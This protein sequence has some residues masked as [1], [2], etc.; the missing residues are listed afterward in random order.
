M[1]SRNQPIIIGQ[2][3]SAR[4]VGIALAI[5]I[6]VLIVGLGV[7]GIK[8]SHPATPARV[9][10]IIILAAL[11]GTA[12][13]WYL[14]RVTRVRLEFSEDGVAAIGVVSVTRYPLSAVRRVDTVDGRTLRPR[15]TD[16]EGGAIQLPVIRLNVAP[17][18]L[19]VPQLATHDRRTAEQ[20]ADSVRWCLDRVA[21]QARTSDPSGVISWASGSSNQTPPS[22]R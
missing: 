11:L 6:D 2:K 10:S 13:S 5:G 14:W 17:G 1:T 7:A 21:R 12:A 4:F 8:S 16:G 3:D 22:P 9:I 18:D 19:P 15:I 20:N